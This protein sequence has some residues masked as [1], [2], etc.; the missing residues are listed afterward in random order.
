MQSVQIQWGWILLMGG[1]AALMFATWNCYR[2]TPPIPEQTAD[3][4]GESSAPNEIDSADGRVLS[5][6]VESYKPASGGRRNLAIVAIALTVFLALAVVF[7][8]AGS[9]NSKHASPGSS[10][11]SDSG[12]TPTSE[13]P[14]SAPA[15]RNPQ[16]LLSLSGSGT[17]STQVIMVPSEWSLGWSYDCSNFGMQGNFIV[18][19][20][21]AD[22]SPASPGGVNQLGVRGSDTEYFHEGGNIYLEINSECRWAVKVVG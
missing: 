17:K 9:Q 22:G 20:Y 11:P 2:E 14:A 19:I 12:A 16:V 1:S 6:T 7:S 4:G 8:L 15:Q 13:S 21:N 10:Q 3:A 5:L 18:S